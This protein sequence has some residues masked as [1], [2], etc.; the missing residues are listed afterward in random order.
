MGAPE[1]RAMA[2]ERVRHGAEISCHSGAEIV[3]R[4]N[5]G[6]EKACDLGYAATTTVM[7]GH[8]KRIVR[9]KKSIWAI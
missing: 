8:T 5:G 9:R 3:G 4:G 1:P 2:Q 6:Q 7:G